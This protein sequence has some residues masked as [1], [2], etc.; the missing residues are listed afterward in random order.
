MNRRHTRL[1]VIAALALAGCT[2]AGRD[3]DDIT[4]ADSAGVEIVSSA[5]ADTPLPWTFTE[6]DLLRDS[7]GEPYLFTNINSHGV[8]VDS[9]GRTVLLSGR[10]LVRFDADGA[11]EMTVGRKGGGPGEM[12]L[13]SYLV[14]HADTFLVHDLMKQ[15]FV[16]WDASLGAIGDRR[17]DGALQGVEHVEFYDGGMWIEKDVRD[18]SLTYT[19]LLADTLGSAALHRV[20]VPNNGA[21]DF[22]CIRFSGMPPLFS[23]DL[24]WSSRG[25]R[26]A[27]STGPAFEIWIRDGSRPVMSI[28]RGVPTRAPT[29]ADA[30]LLHPGGMKVL[31]PTGECLVPVDDIVEKLKMAETFPAI[32]DM[33]LLADGSLWVQRTIRRAANPVLDIFDPTGA[34]VGT[35][36]DRQL[37]VG[38]LPNGDLLIPREDEDTG[39]TFLA[40][41]KV[42]K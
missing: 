27:V 2:A 35:V 28:R 32:H 4:R 26:V 30:E 15:A 11:Y 31:F 12:E 29:V 1:A 34:Y 19:V 8:L 33:R 6:V 17:L 7:V 38:M 9:A 3:G 42:T 21:A 18:D 22:G 24:V 25:P 10:S 37:P 36:H 41:V 13:P 20:S 40:R 5:G 39:G 23:P 16:R 14:M